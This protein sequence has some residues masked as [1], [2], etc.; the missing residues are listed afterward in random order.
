M[1]K[2]RYSKGKIDA[3]GNFLDILSSTEKANNNDYMLHF[4][5]NKTKEDFKRQVKYANT[6]NLFLDSDI[7]SKNIR[8]GHKTKTTKIMNNKKPLKRNSIQNKITSFWKKSFSIGNINMFQNKIHLKLDSSKNINSINIKKNFEQEEEKE[9]DKEKDKDDDY[10]LFSEIN[11]TE[12]KRFEKLENLISILELV[13]IHEKT[14]QNQIVDE[15]EKKRLNMQRDKSKNQL[16]HT[17]LTYDKNNLFFNKKCKYKLIFDKNKNINDIYVHTQ[18]NNTNKSTTLNKRKNRNDINNINNIN[19]LITEL[20]LDNN[21]KPLSSARTQ[22]PL[23]VFS[24]QTDKNEPNNNRNKILILDN[25]ETREVTPFTNPYTTF[26]ESNIF[27]TYNN[28]NNS[29]NKIF[30]ADLI[31]NGKKNQNKKISKVYSDIYFNYKKI[32]DELNN[33]YFTERKEQKENKKIVNNI[34]NLIKKR[35]T[36]IRLLVKELNLDYDQDKEKVNLEEI[37]TNKRN[38]LKERMKSKFQRQLLNQIQQQVLNEDKILSK[39]ILLET[40]IEKKLNSRKKKLNE[41]MFE[42][43]TL[44]RKQIKN[45]II[46]FKL[47]YEKDYINKLM[48]DDVLNFNVPKSLEALLHKYKI[49]KFN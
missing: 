44:K 41:K 16:Y 3:R 25:T 14:T 39:K 34:K 24:N 30:K 8:K 23:S 46:G 21:N 22:R 11:T 40:N 19:T 9:K 1:N 32:K 10:I 45:H 20:K 2:N 35:K 37:I 33:Y 12:R 29:K 48:K 5:V 38:K 49:M 15:N 27:K 43:L 17:S 6:K 7:Y 31:L 18:K 28:S 4:L 13:D 26:S 47:K 36:N 42:E